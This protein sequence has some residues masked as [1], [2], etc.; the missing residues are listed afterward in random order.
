MST[1]N[2]T[3][4][5]TPDEVLIGLAT[6]VSILPVMLLVFTWGMVFFSGVQRQQKRF[7]YADMPQW[8]TM[9]SL[10]CV[11]LSLVMTTSKGLITLETLIVVMSVAILS[12]VWFFL[13]RGRFE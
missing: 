13:S 6:S 12:G 2:L 3:T 10:S 11:L 8:A 9:A 7:G 5:N 4:G 1:F